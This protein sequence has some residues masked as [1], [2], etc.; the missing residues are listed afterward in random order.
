MAAWMHDAACEPAP[1]SS[2]AGLRHWEAPGNG[3][4]CPLFVRKRLGSALPARLFASFSVP[5]GA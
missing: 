5:R 4:Q 3:W 2:V 1:C